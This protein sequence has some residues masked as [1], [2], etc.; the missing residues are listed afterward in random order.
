MLSVRPSLLFL[1]FHRTFSLTV[2]FRSDNLV[3]NGPDHRIFARLNE[4]RLEKVDECL[5]ENKAVE[6]QLKEF[7]IKSDDGEVYCVD[8]SKHRGALGAFRVKI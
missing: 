3:G 5:L 4:S 2:R 7:N 8:I 6:L 1:W